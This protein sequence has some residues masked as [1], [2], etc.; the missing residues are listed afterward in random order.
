[1]KYIKEKLTNSYI[2]IYIILFSGFAD[3]LNNIFGK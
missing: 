1:M 3:F 2:Y